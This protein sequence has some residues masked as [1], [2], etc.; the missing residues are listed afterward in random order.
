MIEINQKTA[1]LRALPAAVEGLKILHLS[2]LHTR[3]FGPAEQAA[4]DAMRQLEPD[5]VIFSGDFCYHFGFS[6]SLFKSSTQ[7]DHD[8]PF[9]SRHGIWL[10]PES[11]KAYAVMQRLLQ[12]Y[13][14]P[15]GVWA[16]RG[17]HDPANFL[18]MARDLNLRFLHNESVLLQ[19]NNCKIALTG[20]NC[21]TRSSFDLVEILRQAARGD[22]NLA[23]SHYPENAE[24]LIAGGMDLVLAG[25]THGGQI[26]LPGGKPVITH[27]RTGSYYAAGLIRFLQGQVHVSRGLG[28]IM[29]PLRLNCPPE[30]TLITL[31]GK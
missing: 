17:N 9:L 27:S 5:M 6:G 25:H 4:Y 16:G 23:I 24:P 21:N 15:L 14:C 31:A 2:D 18:Q 8:Y 29:I 11:D 28:K 12:D 10:P 7:A 1:R 19:Y 26:C 22:L 20:V 3:G 30:I 13:N